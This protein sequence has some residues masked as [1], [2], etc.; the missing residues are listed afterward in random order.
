MSFCEARSS[1]GLGSGPTPKSHVTQSKNQRPKKHVHITHWTS[2]IKK[3]RLFMGFW[4]YTRHPLRQMN[5]GTCATDAPLAR[6]NGRLIRPKQQPIAE[7]PSPSSQR[8]PVNTGLA[9]AFQSI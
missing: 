3:K 4:N 7:I 5:F 6:L 2:W 9:N 8:T 1:F